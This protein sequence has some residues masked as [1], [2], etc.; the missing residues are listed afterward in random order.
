M[1]ADT[2]FLEENPSFAPVASW[3]T[4]NQ[5][6]WPHIMLTLRHEATV[7][8]RLLRGELLTIVAAMNSRLS[9]RY[10]RR[11]VVAPVRIIF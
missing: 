8:D 4:I 2:L 3:V 1:Y 7:D 11:H 6:E 5:Q 10:F 9:F